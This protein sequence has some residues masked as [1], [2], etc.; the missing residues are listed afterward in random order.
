MK[1]RHALGNALMEYLLLSALSTM[2]TLGS[3][4]SFGIAI[5]SNYDN[6]QKAISTQHAPLINLKK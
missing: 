2:I 3:I 4:A 6:L 1:K 5:K